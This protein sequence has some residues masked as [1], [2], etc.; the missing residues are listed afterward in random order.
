MQLFFLVKVVDELVLVT[1]HR[2]HILF[3]L[4]LL[5]SHHNFADPAVDQLRVIALTLI[6]IV[7]VHI[8]NIDAYLLLHFRVDLI[9][10]NSMVFV[11]V[12]LLDKTII[13]NVVC[14]GSFYLN[15]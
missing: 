8:A 13:V 4:L 9:K 1:S 14:H 12:V 6:F 5:V 11:V 15:K 2:C 10:I 3:E 7:L